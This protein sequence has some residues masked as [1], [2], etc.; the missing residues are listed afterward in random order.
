MGATPTRRG[1]LMIRFKECPRCKGDLYLAEDAYGRYFSCLQCG[2][3][4]DIK[5]GE[6]NSEPGPVPSEEQER[7]VA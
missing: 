4:H 6:S 3:L 2:Y 5:Q 1:T 7:E